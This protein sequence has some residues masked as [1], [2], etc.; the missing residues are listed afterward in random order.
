MNSII[1]RILQHS[2][3]SRCIDIAHAQLVNESRE[4]LTRD[5]LSE[6]VCYLVFSSNRGNFNHFLFKLLFNK[7]SVNLHMLSPVM[8]Y[9]IVSNITSSFVVTE[10][11][12]WLTL[13]HSQ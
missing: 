12:H 10:K 9:R 8:L 13:F 5:S 4:F 11:L 2:P 6:N 7:E 1:N 3:S